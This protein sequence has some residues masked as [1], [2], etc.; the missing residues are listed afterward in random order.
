MR[1]QRIQNRL[2]QADLAQKS[3]VPLAT[4]RK[5]ERTGAISLESFLKLGTVLGILEN[6]VKSLEP[7]PSYASLDDILKQSNKPES[8]RVRK[9]KSS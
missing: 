1:Q 7:G 9:K 6:I 4:L 5:F 8:K 2:T 3:G